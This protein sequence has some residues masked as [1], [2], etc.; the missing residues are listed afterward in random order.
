MEEERRKQ[1]NRKRS[2]WS[3]RKRGVK[4]R[5]SVKRTK[6]RRKLFPKPKR[7]VKTSSYKWRI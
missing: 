6:L 5:S 4:R 3:R 7:L 2:A 1:K